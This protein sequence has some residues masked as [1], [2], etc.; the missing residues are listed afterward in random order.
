MLDCRADFQVPT[1]NFLAEVV[2]VVC[3]MASL[4]VDNPGVF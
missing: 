3:Y 4:P 2:K 1:G